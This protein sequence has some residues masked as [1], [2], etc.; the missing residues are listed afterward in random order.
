MSVDETLHCLFDHDVSMPILR[1]YGWCPPAL[2]LGR[3][4]D[5]IEVLEL[6]RCR[7][8]SVDIVRRI[9]GGGTIYHA[10]EMTYSI[11]CTP[12]QI[13]SATSVKDS[14]RILTGFLVEF[15]RL[16]G[17][18]AS[19][20]VDMSS[21][22]ERLGERTAFCFAGKESYDILIDGM[23][24]GG[25]AQRRSKNIIFQHGSIP[26]INRAR[27]GLQYM[28]DRSPGYAENTV[29]L[30]D[31]DVSADITSLKKKLLEAFRRHM[32]VDF[33]ETGLNPNEQ[34]MSQELLLNKYAS[35]R[36]NLRGD[37]E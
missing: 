6:D 8:D 4:Q 36:W 23:K 21:G 30:S 10:D 5:A 20:A 1:T 9:S 28:K 17:L 32:G 3:F 15:Y 25:N 14:F 19:Y 11:V 34:R 13:S 27:H 7:Y 26:I 12:G 2:S 16:L 31:C 24:I 22:G 35:D 18:N 29:S 37:M 33:I